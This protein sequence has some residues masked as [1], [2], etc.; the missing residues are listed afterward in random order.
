MLTVSHQRCTLTLVR[1]GSVERGAVERGPRLDALIEV[2]SDRFRE[3]VH[4]RHTVQFTH[5]LH[6][7]PLL[8]LP[9]IAD[10]ADRLAK[11]SVICERAA[12]PL[13]MPE[14]GPPR[15]AEPRPGD[16][17]R[18]LDHSGSWLTLLD[19]GQDSLYR[20]LVDSCLDEVEPLVNARPGDMRRRV[21]FVFV[22]SPNSITPVHYDIEHSLIL[23]ISGAKTLIVGE[24]PDV[25]ARQHELE[26]YW[27]DGSHGR[28]ASVPPERVRYELSPGVGVY[29]PPF[30]PHWVYNSNAPSLSVTLTF[31]TR[32][33]EDDIIL[34]VVNSRLRRIGLSPR[35]PGESPWSD[36]VKVRMV[37]LYGLRHRLWKQRRPVEQA[38]Y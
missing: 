7:H 21:G 13:L 24:F 19:I 33:S 28:M 3:A 22:S 16:L 27:S 35:R 12:K 18:D 15:G 23:Q 38:M 5:A 29:V 25:G 34:Q 1:E 8:A 9:P 20:D 4:A 30:V 37:R 14:G 6:D 32:D 31:Y 2:D 10:L 17:I 36:R 11:D 26:R